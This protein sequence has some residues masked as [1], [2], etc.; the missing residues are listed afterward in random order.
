VGGPVRDLLLG[1]RSL[2][3]DVVITHPAEPVIQAF[4]SRHNGRIQRR[5]Q[6][7]TYE[8]SFPD[9]SRMDVATARKETYPHPAA[10]PLVQPSE[11]L[12]DLAR[13][14]FSVNAMGI[15]LDPVH[16]G[17]LVDPLGGEMDLR[18]RRLRALHPHSFID[19]PTRIYRAARYAG[20]LN[21]GLEGETAR[22]IT[23]AIHLGIIAKLTPA[24]LGHEWQKILMENDPRGALRRLQ[25]WGALRFLSPGW[26]WR[27]GHER[28]LN[29]RFCSS[30]NGNDSLSFKL[31]SWCRPFGAQAAHEALGHLELP[32]RMRREV[33]LGLA[34]LEAIERRDP[35]TTLEAARA[36][37]AVK[38]FLS[39]ALPASLW[40]WVLRSR[41]RLSGSDLMSLGVPPGPAL[42]RLLAALARERWEK[43]LR[44]RRDEIQYVALETE[45]RG[46]VD[47][48]PGR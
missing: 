34:L 36:P 32:S 10:L 46:Q 42:G 7:M 11:L 23:E 40:K 41:P 3:T 29:P 45:K 6:F 48:P 9:G 37:E 39:R 26:R 30:M 20:R 25:D 17:R 18:T 16:F 43:R 12:H 8:L 1:R 14:D 5:S 24:R 13:R 31:M 28:V 27:P 35:L 44:S 19:D 47:N 33:Q 4:V 38:H 22:W 2:D 21:L 15:S